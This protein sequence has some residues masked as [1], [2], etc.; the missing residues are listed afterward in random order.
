MRNN[1]LHACLAERF[2]RFAYRVCV[3]APGYI[4]ISCACHARLRKPYI[5]MV[6]T[7]RRWYVHFSVSILIL[8]PCLAGSHICS[9]CRI[10]VVYPLATV[11]TDSHQL[12]LKVRVNITLHETINIPSLL[13][14]FEWSVSRR[15]FAQ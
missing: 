14:S 8:N 2:K 11:S 6:S 10:I 9:V 4:G 5:R 12:I 3:S 15:V 13:I 1:S 7:T